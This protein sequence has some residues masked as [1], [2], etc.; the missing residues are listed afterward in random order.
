MRSLLAIAM[1][2][3]VVLGGVVY[4]SLWRPEPKADTP[5]DRMP[6]AATHVDHAHLITQPIR[7]GPEATKA[8]RRK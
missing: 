6:I 8:A 7:S 4:A 3:G 5:W 2:V 1:A